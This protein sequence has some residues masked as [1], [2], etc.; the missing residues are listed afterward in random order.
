MKPLVVFCPC[1]A[2]GSWAAAILHELA[3]RVELRTCGPGWPARDLAAVDA[4]GALCL[5]ELDAAP[6]CVARPTLPPGLTVPRAAWLVDTPR[7]PELH[8]EVAR[9]CELVFHAHPAWAA[10]LRRPSTWLPL[11]VDEETFRPHDV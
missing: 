1:P 4:S 8:R 7:K 5:L 10:A 11:C 2:P 9:D 6:G 3:A